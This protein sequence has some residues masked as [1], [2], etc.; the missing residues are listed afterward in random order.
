[1]STPVSKLWFPIEACISEITRRCEQARAANEAMRSADGVP[2]P[3][4]SASPSSLPPPVTGRAAPFAVSHSDAPLAAVSSAVDLRAKNPRGADIPRLRQDVR[5]QLEVLKRE[6]DSSLALRDGY[7]VLY[8]L[9][10]YADELIANVTDERSREWEALHSEWYE[11]DDGGEQFYDRLEPLLTQGDT[12]ALVYQV[13]YFCLRSG[14]VG[15]IEDAAERAKFTARVAEKVPILP[16]PKAAAL[17]PPSAVDARTGPWARRIG[18][19]NAPTLIYGGSLLLMWF[20]Y[21]RFRN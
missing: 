12:H 2:R 10:I 4:L 19:S 6:L 8:P 14:F 15:R 18:V 9:V 17:P 16:A 7:F 20:T 21:C 5:V 13:Y 1:M 3:A 11:S